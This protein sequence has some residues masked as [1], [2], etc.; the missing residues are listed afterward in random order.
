MQPSAPIAK[1]ENNA[2]L[3]YNRKVKKITISKLFVY[4]YRFIIGYIF[5]A[6]AFIALLITMPMF[7]QS[8]LSE[9][10][11]NSATS[12]YFLGKNGILNG[13][14]VDLPYR[15]L[16]KASILTFGLT[17][18]SIKLPSI[19]IGLLLGFLLI[20]L[21]NRWFKNNVSLLGSCL[22]ILST[23]FLFLAGNGTPL[24]MIV[25]WPTLLL[26]LGSKIQGE[27]HPR[28]LYCFAFILAML[29]S[30]FTPYMIYF[31]ICCVFFAI[32]QPHLRFVLK[33]LPKFPLILCCLITLAGF[34]ALGISVY[35]HPIILKELFF[36]ASFEPNQFF[37][38]ISVGMN[39]LFSWHSN[40]E[41]VFLSPL[42]GLPTF[43]L[44]LIGL[45][46]TTKGFFAS[47][48]S[49]ATIL[50]IF[51]II[52]TG[53]NPDAVIFI[54]LPFS[55]LIAHGI[56]Y[57]LEKWYGLFPENPYARIMALLPLT[58]LFVLMILPGL[59]QYYYGYRNNPN[60]ADEYSDSLDVIHDNL[61]NEILIVYDH[62]EFYKIL[63][64]KTN[65]DIM[66]SA[67]FAEFL[68]NNP[69]EEIASRKV[70][71]LG[72]PS[73]S[74]ENYDLTRIITSPKRNNSDI[75]YLYTYTEGGE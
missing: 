47:R 15:L 41:G 10:E 20:L 12:S 27:K 69:Q 73:E 74:K 23:P 72:K 50:I 5:L 19:I 57:L 1:F 28:A 31:A 29:L 4:R 17:A 30:I 6:I 68:K 56:K 49:I 38:N 75:L 21:L 34:A 9:A 8:G 13:D 14:L 35:H 64:E 67:E 54:I 48:N 66:S 45:F 58:I 39:R 25:F 16:Q 22:I 44:A 55:I 7:A 46:S 42:I 53:F 36:S 52:I 61:D 70:A 18:Y 71:V 33:N 59:L 32:M 11:I 60:V 51:C 37:H 24:I 26:W 65:L 3:C 2:Y 40:P 43:A 63:E 62:Y